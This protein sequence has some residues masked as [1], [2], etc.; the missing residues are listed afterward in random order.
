M[1]YLDYHAAAPVIPEA[2]AAMDVA[3]QEA[4]ANPSSVHRAG[5]AAK[6][7]LERAREQVAQALGAAPGDVILTGGGTEA[8]N[9]F[10]GSGPV[11]HVVTTEIEHPAVARS[12]DRLEASG[13]SVTRLPLPGGR[14]P[15]ASTLEDSLRGP[16]TWVAVQWINH[17]TGTIVPVHD[18]AQVTR[19]RGACLFVDATQAFG[20]L[21]FSVEELGA[22]ALALASHKMGGPAGAGALWVRRGIEVAPILAGGGQERGR[23]PGTPDV[24][25]LAGFGAAAEV[26]PRRLEALPRIAMLRDRLEVALRDL[27]AVVNGS[28]GERIGTALNV[29]VPGARGE[30]LVAALDLEGVCASSGAACSSGLSE[31]SPVLRAM[32]PEEPWRA[33]S[34]L[35]LSLGPELDE[36]AI[37]AAIAILERVIRRASTAL[38]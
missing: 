19:A 10:L 32:Y 1:I 14:A 12:V 22:D 26:L 11:R 2:L 37:D 5:R 20:K 17:E 27:G 18:Y 13:V 34:A 38:T 30:V 36:A 3:R 29:S 15:S 25:A 33:S 8:V 21:P 9:L 4:W 28:E 23:R 24:V 16:E 31:P 35:R 6:R 7:T